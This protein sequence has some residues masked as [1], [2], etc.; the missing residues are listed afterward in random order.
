MMK[1]EETVEAYISKDRT[2]SIFCP[3]CSLSQT[4]RIED[5]PRDRPNPF[6]Y[7]CPCGKVWQVRLVGFRKGERKRVKLT[8]NFMRLSDP[9]KIKTMCTVEDISRTGMRLSTVEPPGKLSRDDVVKILVVL[10]RPRRTPFEFQAKVRRII[11]AKSHQT[12]AVEFH[13]LSN[14][15]RD[16]LEGYLQ[17]LA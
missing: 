9:L 11:P 6:T 12:I 1:L 5:I 10:D 16:I 2:Y 4:F 17:A 8:A 14:D 13:S 7:D 15:Q 3:H